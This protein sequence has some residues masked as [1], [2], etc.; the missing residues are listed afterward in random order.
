MKHEPGIGYA[1]LWASY[2]RGYNDTDWPRHCAYRRGEHDDDPLVAKHL[3]TANELM[4]KRGASNT[5]GGRAEQEAEAY[6]WLIA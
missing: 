2:E 1:R 3:E 4:G 6:P 5:H